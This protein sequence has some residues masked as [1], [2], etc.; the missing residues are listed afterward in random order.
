MNMK[1][2]NAIKEFSKHTSIKPMKES[3]KAFMFRDFMFSGKRIS[4]TQKFDSVDKIN[5]I[6]QDS[7]IVRRIKETKFGLEYVIEVTDSTMTKT[8][9]ITN[10]FYILIKLKRF[11]TIFRVSEITLL[12]SFNENHIIGKCTL[13]HSALERIGRSLINAIVAK[14]GVGIEHDEQFIKET[15]EENFIHNEDKFETFKRTIDLKMPGKQLL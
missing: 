14:G 8:N 2:Q 5:Y 4:N 13:S 12:G 15:Y 1:V 3:Q 11:S 7:T 6:G 9:I 10:D